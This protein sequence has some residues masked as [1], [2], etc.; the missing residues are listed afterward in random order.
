MK[1]TCDDPVYIYICVCQFSLY[2]HIASKETDDM[3]V[4]AYEVVSR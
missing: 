1:S 3:R 4:N 2:M